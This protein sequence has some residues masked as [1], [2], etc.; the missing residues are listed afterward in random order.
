[1]DL[2]EVPFKAGKTRDIKNKVSEDYLR[3]ISTPRIIWHLIK[4]HKFG[5]VTTWAVL[6]T[7]TYVFPPFWDI[8]GSLVR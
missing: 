2:L 3:G 5:L 1:M 8:L 6:I 4:R 7:L